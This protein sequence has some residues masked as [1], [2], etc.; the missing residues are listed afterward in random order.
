[1]PNERTT[2]FYSKCTKLLSVCFLLAC[3]PLVAS[4]SDTSLDDDVSWYAT[5]LPNFCE[6]NKELLLRLEE[7]AAAYG[8]FLAERAYYGES[9]GFLYA[10][11]HHYFIWGDYV[12]AV[13]A[14]E[15]YLSESN[16]S[17]VVECDVSR[18]L[19]DGDSIDFESQAGAEE[20]NA[21]R[22][23]SWTESDIEKVFSIFDEIDSLDEFRSWIGGPRGID[24]YLV[25]AARLHNPDDEARATII[26]GLDRILSK[27]DRL[28]R[29]TRFTNSYAPWVWTKWLMLSLLYERNLVKVDDKEKLSAIRSG[30]RFVAERNVSIGNDTNVETCILEKK[31]L[32][33][34]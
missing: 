25:L 32:F 3:L 16:S 22:A 14:G 27:G 23:V 15:M 7:Q 17:Q 31:G 10:M 20:D 34:D 19:L 13:R 29:F 2:I 30:R 11:S 12:S 9:S 6:N 4:C 26:E 1:M 28:D 18:L 24:A 33:K 8:S 5:T 21:F